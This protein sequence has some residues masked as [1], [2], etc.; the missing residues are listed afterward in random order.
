[1][2]PE[3][4]VQR[5]LFAA[6]ALALVGHTAAAQRF[7][8]TFPTERSATP[9]DVRCLVMPSADP[10]GEPRLQVSDAVTTAQV[11][12]VDVDGWRPGAAQGVDAKAVGYP[13]RSLR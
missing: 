5:P 9:L 10:A 2:L 8:V 7:S 3:P 4:A 1:L 12:G 11:F 13:L 6:V